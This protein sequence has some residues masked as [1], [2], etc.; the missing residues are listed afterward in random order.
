MYSI[1]EFKILKFAIIMK[2]T[3]HTFILLLFISF[4]V[5]AQENLVNGVVIDSL[6][7]EPLPFTNI[8]VVGK[9]LGSISNS[10]GSYTLSLEQIELTDTVFFS[11]VGYEQVRISVTELINNST[12]KLSENAVRLSDFSVLSREYTP[13]EILDLAKKNYSKNHSTSFQKRQVFSRDAAY[14]TFHKSEI[15][16]KKSTF[17]AIDKN[18]ID[19]FNEDLPKELNLYNDYLVYMLYS[20]KEKKLIPIEGQSLVENWDFTDEFDNSVKMLAGDIENNVREDENYFKVRSGI[21]A[22]KLDFGQDTAFTLTDDSLHFIMSNDLLKGE[23]NYLVKNYSTIYSKRWDFFQE[24]KLYNYNLKDIAIV[25]DE[26]A[27]VIEFSPEK[28]KGKYKGTICIATE[29]FALLQVDYTFEEGKTGKGVSLLGVA[30]LVENRSGRAIFEKGKDGH[31]LKYISR[32]SRERYGVDRTLALKQKQESGMID[33]T[34]QEVK[35]KLDMDLTFVQK[36]E[37]L[38]VS[39]EKITK[40]EFNSTEEPNEMYINKVK[41]YSSDIWENSSIIEPTKALKEYQQQY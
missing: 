11:F 21:F 31:N 18:F 8:G 5:Q 38:V 26:L 13:I 30:Y 6:T 14:T 16:Y 10:E 39:Q 9:E 23:L 24:Y 27:Y 37:L 41:E 3:I 15:K 28:R 1:K 34:L 36:K 12:I 19:Q 29:S 17:D 20:D 2:H 4:G 7:E 33:K 40:E 25:N 35:L 22:G 32:E